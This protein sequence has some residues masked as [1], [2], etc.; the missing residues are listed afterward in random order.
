MFTSFALILKRIY[1]SYLREKHKIIKDNENYSNNFT[2]GT[3]NITYD[4][5]CINMTDS[6]TYLIKECECALLYPTDPQR[7]IRYSI[8]LIVLLLA[9]MTLVFQ[10][11][12]L[13][14]EKY[15]LYLKVLIG[16]PTKVLYLTACF[17]II[18]IIP[19]RIACY[20]SV[21]DIL[22]V[23]ALIFMT[24]HFLYYCRLVTLK[25]W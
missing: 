15:K 3:M 22:S 4:I 12:E 23:L 9:I 2:N 8:E 20:D 1:F 19:L 18:L 25:T 5:V 6:A 11:K 7:V 17:L 10:V 16:N 24:L 21:E 13:L 14:I